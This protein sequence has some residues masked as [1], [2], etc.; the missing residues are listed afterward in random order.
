MSVKEANIACLLNCAENILQ[1]KIKSVATFKN[2]SLF[3]KILNEPIVETDIDRLICK[4][5]GI[6]FIYVI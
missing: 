2:V 3:F 6:F 1:C 4:L 5:S